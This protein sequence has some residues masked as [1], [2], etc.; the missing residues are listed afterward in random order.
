LSLGAGQRLGWTTW[1]GHRR[2][3]APADDVC[4]DAEALVARGVRA[5]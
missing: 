4:L 3:E 1:L 5:A 2:S